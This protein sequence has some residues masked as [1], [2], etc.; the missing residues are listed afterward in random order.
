ME[1]KNQA[2]RC[3]NQDKSRS[4]MIMSFSCMNVSKFSMSLDKISL[5]GF[6]KWLFA[7]L[8]P[9]N[10]IQY[11]KSTRFRLYKTLYHALFRD[12]CCFIVIICRQQHQH[13]SELPQFLILEE[14]FTDKKW[15]NKSMKKYYLER[16][17]YPT[18][19]ADEQWT[20]VEPYLS[21]WENTNTAKE[22]WPMRYCTL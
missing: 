4:P 18:D 13:L 16:Q 14:V 2:W 8:R 9:K 6:S 21:E 10:C 15:Y 17:G 11:S 7:C 3:W 1:P 5:R 19:P 20:A 12:F 22:S